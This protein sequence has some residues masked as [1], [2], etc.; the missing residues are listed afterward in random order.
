APAE[1]VEKYRGSFDEGWDVARERWFAKQKELRLVPPDTDLAPRNPGVEE[2]DSLPENHRKLAAR[3]QEAFAGFLD[4]TDVQIG[5]LIDAL[6]PLGELDNTVI[7]LMSDSGASQEG[8]PFGVLHEMKFFN[9][10]IET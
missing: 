5:R 8:G 10:I 1:Y 6:A 9:F 2:W 7:M 3:L 4:H